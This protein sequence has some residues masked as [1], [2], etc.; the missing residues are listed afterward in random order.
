MLLG[1]KGDSILAALILTFLL[2]S[3]TTM[4]FSAGKKR[5]A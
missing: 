1:G 2:S 5:N 4:H 3:V